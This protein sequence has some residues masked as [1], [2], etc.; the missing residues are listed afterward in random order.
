ML[1]IV[2]ALAPVDFPWSQ[3]V[4]IIANMTMLLI[5]FIVIACGTFAFVFRRAALHLR[6]EPVAP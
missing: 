2:L 5:A 3:G 1:S 6:T 4:V